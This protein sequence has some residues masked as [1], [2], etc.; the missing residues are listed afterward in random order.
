[1]GDGGFGQVMN[2][3]DERVVMIG[4]VVRQWLTATACWPTLLTPSSCLGLC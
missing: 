3:V 4:A 2:G 1:M